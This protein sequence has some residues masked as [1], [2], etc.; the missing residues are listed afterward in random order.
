VVEAAPAQRVVSALEGGYNLNAL[1]PCVVAH[2]GPSSPSEARPSLAEGTL[3]EARPED[4]EAKRRLPAA[5]DERHLERRRARTEARADDRRV[6]AH[7]APLG[8]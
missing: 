4:V 1:G 2:I 7:H 6:L 8:V 5:R 3:V